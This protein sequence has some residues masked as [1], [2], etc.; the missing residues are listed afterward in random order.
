M[1]VTRPILSH[2]GESS[3]LQRAAF[4]LVSSQWPIDWIV[5]LANL[6]IAMKGTTIRHTM[7]IA[8]P[9]NELPVA[10]FRFR[11]ARYS[12]WPCSSPVESPILK[13]VTTS[14]NHEVCDANVFNPQLFDSVF[15]S[16]AAE[17]EVVH[18]TVAPCDVDRSDS[19][20]VGS[21]TG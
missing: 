6:D 21:S 12:A 13:A 17:G 15:D 14:S 4:K 18:N 10:P 20:H 8:C 7:V 19:Q 2:Q 3:S 1:A 5:A 11:D 16:E 9:G